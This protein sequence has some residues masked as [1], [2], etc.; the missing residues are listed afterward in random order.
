MK[1]KIHAAFGAIALLAICVFWSATAITELLGDATAI[2]AVKRSILIGMLVL[3]PS[4]AA[5]GA[6]GFSLGKKWR[7]RLV[8]RKAL[9]MK[10]IAGNGLLV[11]LPSAV[12]LAG[13]AAMGDFDA[14]FAAVQ[15]IELIAGAINITL[16]ALNMRDGLALRRKA[17]PAAAPV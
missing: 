10:I 12:F 9:R 8:A 16:L 2:A 1:S 13:K 5:A 3:I 15:G 17:E 11:L 6:S 7:S 14:A 4:M